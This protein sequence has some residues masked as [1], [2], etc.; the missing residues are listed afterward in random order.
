MKKIW[1][2]LLTAILGAIV[3]YA[4]VRWQFSRDLAKMKMEMAYQG[5]L[6]ALKIERE[7][8]TRESRIKELDEKVQLLTKRMKEDLVFATDSIEKRYQK[9][10]DSLRQDDIRRGIVQEGL[11]SNI[12][13]RQLIRNDL[14][15][16]RDGAKKRWTELRRREIDDIQLELSWLKKLHALD[17]LP[18]PAPSF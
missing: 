7:R 5:K 14:K 8:I 1:E 2:I 18:I 10:L 16:K 12:T 4:G 13:Y 3:A 11:A 9:S 17:T 15:N 6:E